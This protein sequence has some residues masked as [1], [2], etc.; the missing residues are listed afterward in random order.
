MS[1]DNEALPN[2]KPP[3]NT[4]WLILVGAWTLFIW[5]RSLFAGPESRAQSDFVAALV[6]PLFSAVGITDT[7]LMTFIIRKTAHFLE[8]AVLGIL[9]AISGSTKPNWH[10]IVY[11]VA[12]PSIDETIQRFVP[13]RSGQISDVLLDFCGV[14]FGF[15]LVRLAQK[16]LQKRHTQ[17]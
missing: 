17:S 12:V 3:Q 5:S 4:G 8:Y 2:H 15:A 10:Q 1:L 6:G 13:E 14:A 11:G 16:F 7:D 9:L